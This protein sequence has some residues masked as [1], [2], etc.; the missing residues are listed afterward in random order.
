MI[1]VEAQGVIQ[2]SLLVLILF[3]CFHYH[4]ILNFSFLSAQA[5]LLH[6]HIFITLN[7]LLVQYKSVHSGEKIQCSYAST[8]EAAKS[9]YITDR[10]DLRLFLT[11]MK[12]EMK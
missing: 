12:T 7:V 4:F 1:F 11:E 3:F 9:L 8:H 6:I 2:M 5:R 10:G